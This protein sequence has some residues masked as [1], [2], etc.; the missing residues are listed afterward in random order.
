MPCWFGRACTGREWNYLF[1]S[2]NTKLQFVGKRQVLH[3]TVL[4]ENL[5]RIVSCQYPPALGGAMHNSFLRCS[6]MT[7]LF[8]SH[9]VQLASS[10]ILHRLTF[11]DHY[12][13]L[14]PLA[15]SSTPPSQPTKQVPECLRN[16]GRDIQTQEQ[17]GRLP[18]TTPSG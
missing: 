7:T 4:N 3:G 13:I 17:R 6:Q 5:I 1:A 9:F 14:L 15:Q 18:S 8:K 10:P 11:L 2:Q 16:S 12:F